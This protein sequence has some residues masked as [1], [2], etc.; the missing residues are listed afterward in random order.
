MVKLLNQNIIT[1]RGSFM[2]DYVVRF[3]S[4]M[5]YA[6]VFV[7]VLPLMLFGA[8]MNV[9]KKWTGKVRK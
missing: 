8:L 9:V 6:I 7:S 3:I 4:A 5:L 2:F 1:M